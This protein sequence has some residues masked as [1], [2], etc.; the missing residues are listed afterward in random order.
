VAAALGS[1]AVAALAFAVL[2]SV[3]A[4]VAAV[5]GAAAGFGLSFAV[6]RIRGGLDGDGLGAG[7]ELV[8]AATLVAVAIW[9]AV[10][11]GSA[12]VVP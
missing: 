9:S 4:S 6:V 3:P 2:G 10:G 8:F 11:A 1:A 7:V 5:V 12:V